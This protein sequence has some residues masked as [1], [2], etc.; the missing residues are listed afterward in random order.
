MSFLADIR[1]LQKFAKVEQDGEFGPVSARALVEAIGLK[2]VEDEKPLFKRSDLKVC[3]DPG[4]GL[5]N[6]HPGV[7]DPGC[8]FKGI[9]EADL[10]MPWALALNQAFIMLG[11]PTFWTRKRKLDD[12]PRDARARRAKAEGC[13]HFISIHVN[14]ADSASANGVETLYSDDRELALLVQEALVIGTGLTDRG[15]KQRS[16]LAVLKFPGSAALIELGFIQ[17]SRDRAVILDT[18]KQLKTTELIARAVLA[19]PSSSVA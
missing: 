2:T 3:I 14:D 6:V 19:H 18:G 7:P 12:C 11:I 9:E 5:S 15:I 8:V 17:N 10:V 1:A 4:H 16:E 13:T